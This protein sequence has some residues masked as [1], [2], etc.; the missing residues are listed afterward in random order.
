MKKH[1]LNTLFIFVLIFSQILWADKIGRIVDQYQGAVS[2]ATITVYSSETLTQILSV[3][4]DSL[5]YFIISDTL[6]DMSNSQMLLPYPN[7]SYGE[8]IIPFFL[9]GTG[10]VSVD[11]FDISGKHIKNYTLKNLSQGIQQISWNGKDNHGKLCPMGIYVARMKAGTHI[12]SSKITRLGKLGGSVFPADLSELLQDQLKTDKSH[13]SISYAG[14]TETYQDSI[15]LFSSDTSFYFVNRTVSMPFKAEGEFMKI[16]RNGTYEPIFMKGVNLGVAVPGTQPGQMAA[17]REQYIQWIALMAE[18]GLNY[19]RTYT[20]HYPR[21]YE[22]LAAYNTA[23]PKH[24]LFLLQGVWLDEEYEDDLFSSQTEKFD[25]DIEEVIDCL[26]G[27]RTI[28]HRYGRAYGEFTADVVP[29][30]A[31]YIIG[32]EIH[33]SEVALAEMN[34]PTYSSHDGNYFSI[35]DVSPLDAWVTA[36]LDH[37]ANYED[38]VYSTK[39]PVSVSSWPTLDPLTHPT[40]DPEETD[41]DVETLDMADIEINSHSAGF[42][43]SYHA[44]PYYPDFISE[45]PDYQT[46]SDDIG[47]NSYLGYLYELN[48]HYENIPLL[49]AEYG[50]PSSWGNAH[51]AFSGMHHGGFSEKEQGETDVRMLDNI[52]ESGCAGGMMFAWIDEWFKNAWITEPMGSPASRRYMWQNVTSSE[53]NYGLIGFSEGQPD[54]NKWFSVTGNSSILKLETDMDDAYFYGKITLQDPLE[55]NDTLWM[56]IDSYDPDLGESRLPDGTQITLRSEFCVAINTSS[57]SP[58]FVTQAYDLFG[59]WHNTSEP[60]QLYHSIVSD[61]GIWDLVKWKNN[62]YEYSYQE[63]GNLRT[64]RSSES[65]SSLDGVR[66]SGKTIEFRLPWT[67]LQVTDPGRRE[68]MDDD[69]NT[70]EREVRITDGI[71]L[72]L[73]LNGTQ[74]TSS[75]YTWSDWDAIDVLDTP[76]YIKNSFWPFI[77]GIKAIPNVPDEDI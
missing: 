24:P 77:N 73:V 14:N 75:R 42:F 49:I 51:F 44:Y 48:A 27:N 22:E 12:S 60:E 37:L 38:S 25:D 54:Y 20:L 59:I 2:N 45:D 56:A 36:R 69:R 21:F 11:I 68:V 61:G 29:W 30:I 23:N 58:L 47:P 52:Y 40:E 7:P 50:V 72:T 4:S 62:R 28:G 67:L 71:A 33:P 31:G 74:L 9:S 55:D 63:I 65:S 8:N 1:F 53:Q 13:I 15:D 70:A 64:R 19:V 43:M 66:I 46:Y 3:T 16:K 10:D 18:N 5:G 76:E 39:I 57:T 26:H 6:S 34:N 17:S 32:R 35:N 41:E